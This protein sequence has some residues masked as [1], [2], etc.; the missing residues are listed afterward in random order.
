M[1]IRMGRRTDPI[2]WLSARVPRSQAQLETGL[3]GVLKIA[4]WAAL[5]APVILVP[6]YYLV[7]AL[8]G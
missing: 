2:R 3:R 8:L 4:F 5:L 1:L 6:L 7:V